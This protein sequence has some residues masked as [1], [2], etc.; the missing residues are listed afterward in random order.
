MVARGLA[1]INVMM[2]KLR[3]RKMDFE[4][5]EEVAGF[6]GVHVEREHAK[7]TQK[8]LPTE[9]L[10]QAL[11]I[12]DPGVLGEDLDEDPPNFAFNRA[13]HIMIGMEGTTA[14]RLWAKDRT[15]LCL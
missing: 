12:E 5:E 15:I 1:D 10:K 4:A 13:T 11:Q 2:D 9:D 6:L 14:F 7:W 8:G 3:A